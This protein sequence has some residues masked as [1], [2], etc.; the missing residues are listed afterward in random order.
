[1]KQNEKDIAS[2]DKAKKKH[3]HKSSKKAAKKYD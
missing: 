1:M 2:R 3:V